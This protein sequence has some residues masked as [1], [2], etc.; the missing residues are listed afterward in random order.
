MSKRTTCYC[1]KPYAPLDGRFFK[2][3]GLVIIAAIAQW[4]ITGPDIAHYRAFG[5]FLAVLVIMLGFL[6][7]A[8]V[9]RLRQ[10]HTIFCAIWDG[11]RS[12]VL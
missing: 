1:G 7:V 11:I 3:G 5:G 4:I 2:L 9:V 6:V 8:T 12:T 10:G